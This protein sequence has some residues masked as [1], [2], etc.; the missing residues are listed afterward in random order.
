MAKMCADVE[1]DH[2]YACSS[3]LDA[4]STAD[5]SHQD[6]RDSR[7]HQAQ[8]SQQLSTSKSRYDAAMSAEVDV[9]TELSFSSDM[10]ETVL[11]RLAHMEGKLKEMEEQNKSQ[12]LSLRIADLSHRLWKP[13]EIL[14]YTSLKETIKK[15]RGFTPVCRLLVFS[16]LS[17]S[18][19]RKRQFDFANGGVRRKP[20]R[21]IHRVARS[22]GRHFQW[23]NS[24]LLFL[25]GCTW[26]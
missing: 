2:T 8:P 15:K 3:S 19:S 14:V 10:N 1:F 24:S 26:A 18:T 20:E 4:E 23:K 13:P 6:H 11:E 21:S 25:P 22:L 16:W 17:P 9:G 5:H 12:A 7:R